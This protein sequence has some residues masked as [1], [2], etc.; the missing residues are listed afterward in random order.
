[1][2]GSEAKGRFKKKGVRT[3]STRSYSETSRYGNSQDKQNTNGFARDRTTNLHGSHRNLRGPSDAGMKKPAGFGFVRLDNLSKLLDIQIMEILSCKQT[4]AEFSA[5]ASEAELKDDFLKRIVL[6][7]GKL[8]RAE[9]HQIVAQ[10]LGQI[11]SSAF[12]NRLLFYI[13]KCQDEEI[14]ESAYSEAFIFFD[15][16]TAYF[17][18]VINLLPTLACEKLMPV[19]RSCMSLLESKYFDGVERVKEVMSISFEK[20]SAEKDKRKTQPIKKTVEEEAEH[21]YSPPENFR[22]LS[23]V[24][25]TQDLLSH[26]RSF[27]RHGIIEGPYNDVE[28]YLDVQFRLLREDFVRPLRD[29]VREFISKKREAA[30]A[31]GKG[32]R[33]RVNNIKMYE[34]VFIGKAEICEDKVGFSVWFD[35]QKRFA[36]TINWEQSKRFMNGSLLILTRNGFESIILATVL[37]RHPKDL[38]LGKILVEI[39]HNDTGSHDFKGCWTMAES[40]LFFGAYSHVLDALKK[41][42]E[43]NFPLKEYIVRGQ[44]VVELPD[45]LNAVEYALY[46]L[47]LPSV[48]NA[49]EGDGTSPEFLLANPHENQSWPAA[50]QL[51]LDC[52]QYEAFKGA[53]TRKVMLIQGPPGT[54]KTYLGL[55]IASVLLN[56]SDYWRKSG[57]GLRPLVV[58]CYTNHALDQFLMGL[59]DYTQSIVRVGGGCKEK[60]LDQF[61]LRNLRSD[62]CRGRHLSDMLRDYREEFRTLKYQYEYIE[63]SIV[64][65]Q[66]HAGIVNPICF[67]DFKIISENQLYQ[68]EDQNQ[69]MDWLE[70]GFM[71][72]GKHRVLRRNLDERADEWFNEGAHGLQHSFEEFADCRKQQDIQFIVGFRKLEEAQREAKNASVG[73]YYYQKRAYLLNMLTSPS[74]NPEKLDMV[75]LKKMRSLFHLQVEQRWQLY[76]FWVN[77]LLKILNQTT[78]RLEPELLKAAGNLK[79][80]R[81][82]EDQGVMSTR[83]VIGLTTSYAAKHQSIL[84]QLHPRIV[85]VEEAAEVLEAHVVVS[86]TGS[87]EHLI[88]IG[89]HL[90]LKPNPAV[91]ELGTKY[92]LNVS[93]FERLINNKIQCV[94]LTTQHRMRPEIAELV[95]PTIYP[96]LIN[97][98]SVL[99]YPSI[100]GVT[101]NVAFV[102]HKHHQEEVEEIQ[103]FRNV[104]EATF[105]AA[106]VRYL[107]LQGYKP[108]QITVLA[109]YKGQMFYL[110]KLRQEYPSLLDVRITVVDNYQGEENDIILLSL[111]RSND[112]GEVGFLKIE[113]RVCVALSRAKHGLFIFGNMDNLK[114]KGDI[115]PKVSQVLER[116]D[117]LVE[118][119]ALICEVHSTITQVRC[120][121]DFKNVPEGGC[122][123]QCGTLIPCG[124]TCEQLCH[125]TDRDHLN[126]KCFQPCTKPVCTKNHICPKKCY[127]E[128][129]PCM[130]PTEVLL[131]CGHSAQIPCHLE[132]SQYECVEVVHFTLPCKDEQDVYCYQRKE[133]KRIQCK[134][135]CS[136]RLECGHACEKKCHLFDD[137]DHEMYKCIKPCMENNKDCKGAHPCKKACH[138]DCDLCVVMVEKELPCKHL[139]TMKC[140]EEPSQNFCGEKCLKVCSSCKQKCQKKCKESCDPCSTKVEKTVP[141]CQHKQIMHCG[142]D[143]SS[144]KNCKAKCDRK[145]VGCGHPCSNLCF[146]PC[147]TE[148]KELVPYPKPTG[149]GHTI[150]VP[151]HIKHA[152]EPDSLQLQ[153]LCKE[154]CQFLLEPCEHPCRG[155]CGSCWQGQLHQ[156]CQEPCGRVLVCNHSCKAPCAEIC[157]PCK[158]RCLEKCVHSGCK[159]ICGR[160]CAPCKEKCTRKCQH[161][162]CKKACSEKCNIKACEKPCGKTLTECKHK[163]VGLCGDLCLCEECNEGI[164]EIFLGSEGNEDARFVMLP[165][166]KH[167]FESSDLQQWLR[168]DKDDQGRIVIKEK[169]CPKCSKPIRSCVRYGEYIM[170]HTNDV[171]TVKHKVFG[172]IH[173]VSKIVQ[174]GLKATLGSFPQELKEC[175]DLR[176]KVYQKC[177]T[178][179]PSQKKHYWSSAPIS[180]SEAKNLLEYAKVVSVL[181][182]IAQKALRPPPNFGILGA[183][184]Y[185]HKLKAEEETYQLNKKCKA[186]VIHFVERLA[187]SLSVRNL[188]S[189]SPQEAKDIAAL[190]RKL[191]ILIHLCVIESSP[192]FISISS[193]SKKITE[194]ISGRVRGF[195]L[196]DDSGYSEDM[197]RL[198]I[199]GKEVEVRITQAEI[200]SIVSAMGMGKGHWFKCPNGHV[201]AIGDCGGATMESKCNECGAAIGGGSHR[202]RSDNRFAPEIDGATTTAYP[203][204]AMNPN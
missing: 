27:L 196:Y 158:E 199:V 180:A 188:L 13:M 97:H 78:G 159:F 95:C 36:S 7:L 116:Q 194:E 152:L 147:S 183:T 11:S 2:E 81:M 9:F 124:H 198:K 20:L 123:L 110:H 99:K 103:S 93:L 5:L 108:S 153:E 176:K 8:S 165:D 142:T 44:N 132:P 91:Y 89:D 133:P 192:N 60:Q 151:C 115:W 136:T 17:H 52:S 112:D 63:N 15:H 102:H 57:H 197:K 55:R 83:K 70:E 202:L 59:T 168:Q 137:P 179:R 122:L 18:T 34:D 69:F 41:F 156:P 174:Q 187:K 6:I 125:A 3:Q 61:S 76:R 4:L 42:N 134:A 75:K 92:H 200:R 62:Y 26:G 87:C 160:P 79:E 29:G 66:N 121:D 10:A 173:D 51:G 118:N 54:G 127:E 171:Q 35:C 30:S 161:L 77:E 128:C 49:D 19:M 111:V 150:L 21:L 149:C 90:Q 140:H 96:V 16:L 24:P 94:S 67:L 22:K 193:L 85:I 32:K 203:G 155:T 164:R 148:C 104:H 172:N 80:A 46:R 154:P 72:K 185:R 186:C 166:C 117:A 141:Q 167:I 162:Q 106:M 98:N 38:I 143:P 145:L 53:L 28:H 114:V 86:L 73:N 170:K 56:N 1:M 48:K 100:R 58:V 107:I 120:G 139:W 190:Q 138:Q 119:L 105:I 84:K 146:Q 82:V 191:N 113:N 39:I 71:W 47:P 14:E 50:A 169:V 129:G 12:L 144:F 74:T 65:V 178:S 37:Q 131:D 68:F 40:N 130:V 101:K 43:I 25:T 135:P 31:Q 195:Y 201:Y 189:L 181:S 157:P 109:T 177:L 33:I 64:K 88:M 204:T 163:C 182:S 45:Y 175:L 184:G 23:T 126:S